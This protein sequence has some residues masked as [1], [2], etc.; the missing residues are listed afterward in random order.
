[1]NQNM[2]PTGS[3]QRAQSRGSKS[4]EQDGQYA[5]SPRTAKRRGHQG[6]SRYQIKRVSA[7]NVDKLR[8]WR[9][10]SAAEP[11][12]WNQENPTTY[13]TGMSGEAPSG[14]AVELEGNSNTLRMTISI[15]KGSEKGSTSSKATADEDP[16]NG[17]S[18]AVTSS[19]PT[20]IMLSP[21]DYNASV[22]SDEEDL[23][24][25]AGA[26]YSRLSAK[27]EKQADLVHV[28]MASSEHQLE[29]KFERFL[30]QP[31]TGVVLMNSEFY[32]PSYAQS[33]EHLRR[34]IEGGGIVVVICECIS[35]I[36]IAYCTT[37]MHFMS[38]YWNIRDCA[39]ERIRAHVRMGG[40]LKQK[41]PLVLD[42]QSFYIR[43]V[44]DKDAVSIPNSAFWFHTDSES[45]TIDKYCIAIK[46]KVGEQSMTIDH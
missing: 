5:Q 9:D 2:L 6:K 37:F 16:V 32:N 41:L 4:T 35:A 7:V 20:I 14:K 21:R 46:S 15:D 44:E 40:G 42:C 27:L 28:S 18:L 34:Y 25:T 45:C 30:A 24:I 31:P 29:E 8:N 1:M 10:G 26:F 36:D 23:D 38:V 13:E 22:K 43:H 3:S 39:K 33:H 17:N 11:V 12:N 19:K